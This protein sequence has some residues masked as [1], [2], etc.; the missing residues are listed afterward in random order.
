MGKSGS[1]WLRPSRGWAVSMAW[2]VTNRAL[3]F[4]LLSQTTCVTPCFPD[5][6]HSLQDTLGARRAPDAMHFAGSFSADQLMRPAKQMRLEPNPRP[7]SAIHD[8]DAFHISDVSEDEYFLTCNLQKDGMRDIEMHIPISLDLHCMVARVGFDRHALFSLRGN[9]RTTSEQQARDLSLWLT[10][11]S[12]IFIKRSCNGVNQKDHV[13]FSPFCGGIGGWAHAARYMTKHGYPFTCPLAMDISQEAAESYSRSHGLTLINPPLQA[14]HLQRP[15]VL[16]GDVLQSSP[17]MGASILNTDIV[18][19]SWPCVTF[20][21]AGLQKGWSDDA[22]EMFRFA[23]Q[24]SRLIGVDFLL[25]ENVPPVWTDW[26]WRS[27][28]FAELANQHFELIFADVI[29]TKSIVPADRSR[30]IGVAVK[31]HLQVSWN[32]QK[33]RDVMR[34]FLGVCKNLDSEGMWFD[35]IPQQLAC[36]VHLRDDELQLYS[37]PR[38]ASR[39]A[40]DPE[41]FRTYASHHY[42]E[43][44]LT[45]ALFPGCPRWLGQNSR[46]P[47]VGTGQPSE[48]VFA[49]RD[50]HRHGIHKWHRCSNQFETG[51]CRDWQCNHATSR[52]C[53]FLGGDCMRRFADYW[54][55]S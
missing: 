53:C 25:L 45:T 51:M 2:R 42:H 9:H 31:K 7:W 18:T 38:R 21:S 14:V 8:L 52:T 11:E 16:V 48:I 6:M 49:S 44:L 47:S 37:C 3:A 15:C 26:A 33:K 40:R 23:V 5:H 29:S 20:S 39:Y 10:T 54:G 24:Q 12:A 41:Q 50:P 35:Q 46:Q 28:L 22:R 55:L 13:I 30:F 36:Q 43:K 32:L 17:W 34:V 4:I 27:T 19:I 1:S